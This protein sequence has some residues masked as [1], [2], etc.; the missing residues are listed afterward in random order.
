MNRWHKASSAENLCPIC[1]YED[2]RVEERLKKTSVYEREKDI[3]IPSGVS[4]QKS[5]WIK[6]IGHRH[7]SNH[8]YILTHRIRRI[9]NNKIALSVVITYDKC[10]SKSK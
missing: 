3:S 1:P 6:A 5:Y 7:L 8:V 2:L 10:P 9:S 4:E